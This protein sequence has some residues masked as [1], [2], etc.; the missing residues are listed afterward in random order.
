MAS[1]FTRSRETQGGLTVVLSFGAF[2]K[3]CF[4]SDRSPVAVHGRVNRGEN[5]QLL[6]IAS[7]FEGVG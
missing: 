2:I 6:N 3:G 5:L 7:W 4:S 1:R